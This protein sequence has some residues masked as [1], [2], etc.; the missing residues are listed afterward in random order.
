MVCW[1]FR[2]HQY[3]IRGL[4]VLANLLGSVYDIF[5]WSFSDGRVLILH[6]ESSLT[7]PFEF[8]IMHVEHFRGLST[9]CKLASASPGSAVGIWLEIIVLAA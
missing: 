3:T 8:L 9:L 6:L 2:P 1:R 7:H 5:D 4:V